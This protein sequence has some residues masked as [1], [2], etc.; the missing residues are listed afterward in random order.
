M[1]KEVFAAVGNAAYGQ[2]FVTPT[3]DFLGVSD[4]T[5]RH[6]LAGKYNI[7]AMEKELIAMLEMRKREIDQAISL[8]K[9]TLKMNTA[10][11]IYDAA[12]DSAC[13][14]YHEYTADY[15]QL[16]AENAMNI[17]ISTEL[18]QTIADKAKWANENS[19][20]QNDFYYE[21][22]KPLSEIQIS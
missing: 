20:N 21:V 5:V 4:R 15:V 12:F 11:D 3:S 17:S 2:N 22:E 7:P 1:K 18:A 13:S 14:E 8:L 6:W 16:Y 19:G 10:Y 9:E